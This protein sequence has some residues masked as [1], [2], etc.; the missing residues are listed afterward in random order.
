MRFLFFIR[1]MVCVLLLLLPV[2]AFS[3]VFQESFTRIVRGEEI[4][5]T[6]TA[7]AREQG[8]TAA[9][10][11][12]ISGNIYGEFVSVDPHQFLD[13]ITA[14]YNILWY[15][16]NAK[17]Y[18]Y[19]QSDVVS[20]RIAVKKGMLDSE[21]GV[22]SS[23][24]AFLKR[25]NI[26]SPYIKP[27]LSP[28]ADSMF[29]TAP[30]EYIT[31]IRFALASAAHNAQERSIVRVFKLRHIWADDFTINTNKGSTVIPGAASI[32]RAMATGDISQAKIRSVENSPTATSLLGQGLNAGAK[33]V[34][35]GQ[36]KQVQQSKQGQS[37]GYKTLAERG[38]VITAEPRI[39]AV[40]VRDFAANMPMYAEL[41]Q[42]IDIPQRLIQIQAIIVDVNVDFSRD[43]GVDWNINSVA[44]KV[45]FKGKTAFTPKLLKGL[46]FS[47]IFTSG[48]N[49]FMATVRALEATGDSRVLGQP[50]VLTM[51]NMQATLENTQTFYV[52]IAGAYATD[53]YN[54]NSGTVLRVTPSIVE[55]P[56]TKEVDG[57]RILVHVKDGQG[58]PSPKNEVDKI[59]VVK[60]TTINT[61][62]VIKP[63][64][65]L[66]LGGYYYETSQVND[67]GVPGL[68]E[69]PVLNLFFGHQKTVV[70]RMQRLILISPTVIDLDEVKD[71]TVDID[72]LGFEKKVFDTS[73]IQPP[74][75]QKGIIRGGCARS[76]ARPTSPSAGSTVQPVT[77]LIP[78][79]ETPRGITSGVM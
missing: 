50:S 1:S 53:L 8:Y 17:I 7:F 10:S 15:V 3:A 77:G 76:S 29:V 23:L 47:T 63:G 51:E 42:A 44:D 31:D 33:D 6:L 28:S 38:I 55:D 68:K 35:P 52:R 32:L 54:V 37:E 25:N 70:K 48:S 45:I 22:P 39:N 11:S 21:P 41:I 24:S 65:S 13:G 2:T 18:F 78:P 75:Q 20:E 60:A 61:Q 19:T 56:E 64:Q 72:K 12:S 69:V 59:P 58:A 71:Q 36:Q 14:A 40:I 5:Q 73:V 4:Q 67:D 74:A 30:K 62:A 49:T 79:V 27:N 16:Y 43:L 57:I 34:P 9:I 46:D 66:L 26:Y